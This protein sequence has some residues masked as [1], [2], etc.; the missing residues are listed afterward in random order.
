MIDSRQARSSA[1]A[2]SGHAGGSRLEGQRR[3][4]A[5][6]LMARRTLRLSALTLL[7]AFV[8]LLL[9]AAQDALPLPIR[10]LYA[11]PGGDVVGHVVVSAILALAVRLA[12]PA[13]IA[14]H[15]PVV[16]HWTWGMLGLTV[17]VS[18]EE[19]AQRWIP[20]RT[21]SWLDWV[22]SLTGLALGAV[23]ARWLDA[24]RAR[25]GRVAA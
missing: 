8:V 21:A 14:A 6:S 24:W 11:F 18:V 19:L 13:P 23:L 15:V 17:L 16:R 1:T 3:R 20:G 5:R 10:R 9:A 25:A 4:L 22:A 7:V 2:F 12:L